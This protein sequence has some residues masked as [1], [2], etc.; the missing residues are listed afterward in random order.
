MRGG[1]GGGGGGGGVLDERDLSEEA[2]KVE[3][4]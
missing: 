1:G 2:T 4:L 3:S